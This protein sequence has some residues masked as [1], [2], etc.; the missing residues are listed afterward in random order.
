MKG[1]HKELSELDT[2]LAEGEQEHAT[3]LAI[4]SCLSNSK[5]AD[6]SNTLIYIR[7]PGQTPYCILFVP[8]QPKVQVLG[9]YFA[10]FSMRKAPCEVIQVHLETWKEGLPFRK[11]S[12]FRICN[13]RITQ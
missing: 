6:Y 1:I 11:N 9:E 4:N 13:K 10:I 2:D 8:Q 5:N 3:H 12:I 7:L